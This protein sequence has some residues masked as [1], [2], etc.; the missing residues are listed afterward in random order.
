MAPG[1]M[2]IVNA[3][4]PFEFSWT[5]PIQGQTKSIGT[6]LTFAASGGNSAFFANQLVELFV[7]AVDGR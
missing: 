1:G 7:Y 5:T 3:G 2:F 6:Q 4:K